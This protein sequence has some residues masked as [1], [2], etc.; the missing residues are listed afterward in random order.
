MTPLVGY[1]DYFAGNTDVFEGVVADSDYQVTFKFTETAVTPFDITGFSIIPKHVF[2]NIA[3]L[4]MPESP[5][6]RDAG[7]VIGTGPFKFANMIEREQYVL[8][9]HRRLLAKCTTFRQ[10]RLESYCSDCYD[11]IT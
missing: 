7:K 11:R 8:E 1:E 9:G 4:D 10:D 6:S 5:E 3:V 2:E